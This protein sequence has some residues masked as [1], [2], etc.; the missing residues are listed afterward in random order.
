M[1][2]DDRR[3]VLFVSTTL[4]GGGAERFVTT[5]ARHLDRA[6]FEPHLAVMRRDP[7]ETGPDGVS[8][9]VLGKRRAW[10]LPVAILRLARAIDALRPHAVLSAFAHPNWVTGLALALARSKPGWITRVSSPP[11]L[12]D[13]R[14]MRPVMR[15]AYARADRVVANAE[16]LAALVARVYP[17]AGTITTL[18]NATDFDQLDSL[19]A[20][21]VPAPLPGRR[22]VL[23]VG[24]LVPEKR[25]DLLVSAAGGLAERI[26]L[27]V[28]ICGDGPERGNLEAQARQLGLGDRVRFCGFVQNPWAWMASAD[29]FALTSDMEGLPNALVE[30]QALGIAAVATDCP[31]GPAEIIAPGQTGL[32]VAPGDSS[33]LTAALGQ[34]LV[35]PATRS[36]MGAAGRERTRAR[37]GAPATTRALE[38]LVAEV[39][40]EPTD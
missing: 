17:E 8:I 29:V 38:T 6:R 34:L 10:Q 33:A 25:L 15:W 18:P 35:D 14:W 4:S 26:D 39:S 31:T 12:T 5:V 30:A 20:E 13:P 40:R 9:T 23:A 28:V 19:A 27:E 11:A 21:P 7:Q 2:S 3:R 32:L 36:A 16:A 1:P 22:R 24:R 37:Y